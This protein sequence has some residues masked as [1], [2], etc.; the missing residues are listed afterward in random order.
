MITKVAIFRHLLP[1]FGIDRCQ[2]FCPSNID[3]GQLYFGNNIA[4]FSLVASDLVDG[5]DTWF[6]MLLY[7]YCNEAADLDVNNI[8]MN[9]L[10]C[11]GMR[12]L[13]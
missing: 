2:L 11:H 8:K 6:Q 12:R 3:I 10:I 9:N 7:Y 5:A 13:N 4:R 1:L